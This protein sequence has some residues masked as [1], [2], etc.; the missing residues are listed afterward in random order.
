M[1][2]PRFP[3]V[4][5]PDVGT[6][7]VICKDHRLVP[8]GPPAEEEGSGGSSRRIAMMTSAACHCMS[9]AT[10]LSCRTK[11][12]MRHTLCENASARHRRLTRPFFCGT[13][14]H[15]L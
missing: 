2:C 4:R 11:G 3:K 14:S 6:A 10:A 9:V 7:K 12:G 5:R 13:G 1:V 15:A 8:G